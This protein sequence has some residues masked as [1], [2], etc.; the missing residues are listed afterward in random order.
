MSCRPLLCFCATL[1]IVC[2]VS[3][4]PFALFLH[5]P[6]LC[7]RTILCFVS[8][9]FS[10]LF[11]RYSLPHYSLLCFR[12]IL[13]FVSA[14]PFALFLHYSLLCFRTILCFVSALHFHSQ[15][16]LATGLPICVP[17]AQFSELRSCVK[18][19]VAVLG[20]TVSLWT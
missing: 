16:L 3:A 4:L 13:C 7:F 10:A 6:L 9:L 5:Y 12:T 20:R 19:E 15:K 11:P 18:V 17:T 8:A 2:F 1:C 14:L